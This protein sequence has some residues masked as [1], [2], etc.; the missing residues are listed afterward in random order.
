MSIHATCSCMKRLSS[1]IV[2]AEGSKHDQTSPHSVFCIWLMLTACL[3]RAT[4]YVAVGAVDILRYALIGNDR[5]GCS[6]VVDWWVSLWRGSC[7]HR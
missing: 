2:P 5:P 6:L 1:S 7:V 3:S 4:L